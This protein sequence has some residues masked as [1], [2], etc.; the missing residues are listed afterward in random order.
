MLDLAQPGWR[1]VVVERRFLPNLIA[2][3]ALATAQDGGLE[4]RPDIATSVPGVYLAGDWVG[5]EGWLADAGLA[6]AKRAAAA[7]LEAIAAP[8]R[9]VPASVA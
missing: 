8:A 5:S 2:V 4:G 1:D 3:N 9:P 6:S 7:A